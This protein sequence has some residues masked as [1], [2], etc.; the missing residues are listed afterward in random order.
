MRNLTEKQMAIFRFIADYL[1]R[2]GF[3]PSYAEIKDHFSFKRLN[4]VRS[5]LKHIEK[6]GYIRLG[7]GKARSIQ[8]IQELRT[9]HSEEKQSIPILGSIAAGVP[10]WAE[11][12]FDSIL[13]IAPDFFGNG[14]LF[15]VRVVGES[16]TGAGIR[17]CDIAIIHKQAHVE[18]GE[19]AAVLIDKEATL[20]RVYSSPEMIL[21]KADNPN[22]ADIKYGS[23]SKKDISILGKYVGVVRNE[24]N[25]W[26]T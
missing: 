8:L 22:F 11:Q 4:S 3:P 14:E 19:I 23:D 13:P 16:M 26:S 1:E 17:D 7:C 20:K 15:G 18:N 10:I 21:L 6:K 24:W 5:H 2:V 12:N 25:R 9:Q